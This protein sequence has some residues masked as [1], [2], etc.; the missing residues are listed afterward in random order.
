MRNTLNEEQLKYRLEGCSAGDAGLA[1]G[2]QLA[3][4]ASGSL[5]GPFPNSM[6]LVVEC[7]RDRGIEQKNAKDLVQIRVL[8]AST[9]RNPTGPTTLMKQWNECCSA[10][11]NPGK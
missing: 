6:S 10:G 7:L 1:G 5:H 11:R 3:E 4:H 9:P 2:N 8:N